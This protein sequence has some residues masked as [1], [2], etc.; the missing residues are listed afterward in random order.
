MTYIKNIMCAQ[1]DCTDIVAHDHMATI[2]NTSGKDS[3]YLGRCCWFSID[4]THGRKTRIVSVYQPFRSSKRL[5][6]STYDQHRQYFIQRGNSCCLHLIFRTN[7]EAEL[8]NWV[9]QGN[10]IIVYIDTNENLEK[11]NL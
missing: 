5:H 8:R 1:E 2:C 9:A 10:R 7:F 11:G 4:G 3:T 6:V